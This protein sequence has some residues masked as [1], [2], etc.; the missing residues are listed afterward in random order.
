[1]RCSVFS[2]RPNTAQQ[3]PPR[4]LRSCDKKASPDQKSRVNL[5]AAARKGMNTQR[6]RSVYQAAYSVFAARYG[7]YARS[8]VLK[9]EILGDHLLTQARRHGAANEAV[10]E[11]DLD[12][13]I[14]RKR[15]LPPKQ[16]RC[17]RARRALRSLTILA[18]IALGSRKAQSNG[19]IS[20]SF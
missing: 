15:G 13:G 20:P 18:T 16:K 5:F 4:Q 12:R 2:P 6:R 11:S 3:D 7:R 10:L 14:G 9:T 1:M 19:F 17:S 8:D